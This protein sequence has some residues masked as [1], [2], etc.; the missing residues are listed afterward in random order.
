LEKPTP[1]P[2]PPWGSISGCHWEERALKR[3]MRKK[4]ENSREKGRK[5][6]DEEKILLKQ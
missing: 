2:P 3:G 1:I 6:K 4:G 5:G